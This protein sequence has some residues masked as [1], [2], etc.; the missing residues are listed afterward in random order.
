MQLTAFEE[1]VLRE[2]AKMNEPKYPLTVAQ[3]RR[4]VFLLRKYMETVDRGFRTRGGW[5][6]TKCDDETRKL[7][8]QIGADESF[9]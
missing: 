1:A 6:L 3:Q 4:M 5:D 9:R 7:F 8:R 2:E